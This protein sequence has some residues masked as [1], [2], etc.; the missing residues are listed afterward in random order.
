MKLSHEETI[1]RW[2]LVLG[3]YADKSLGAGADFHGDARLD[4]VDH[5]LDF[6]YGREF[7]SQRGVRQG[8]DGAS[9]LTVPEWI[10]RIRRLFPRGAIEVMERHA[11]DR[12]Q[13]TELLTDPEVL[14]RLEP[15]TELLKSIISMKHLMEGEVVETARRIVRRVVD[16]LKAE[17]EQ[18]VRPAFSG[19]IDRSATGVSGG[20]RS[21]DFRRT[22][23]RNLHTY[24]VRHARLM[25]E[26]VYFHGHVRRFN[27][28]RVII[29]V[30]QS[31]SMLDSVIH[32]A[33]MAGIFAGLSMLDTRLVIFDAEVVDLSDHLDDP[34]ETLMSI[35]L[36]GGTDI[37]GA[38]RYCET[39]MSDP[40]R[41]VLVLVSDLFEGGAYAE[42]YRA[43]QDIITAGAKVVVLTALDRE[44]RP[45]FDRSAAG[46]L[47]SIGANVAAM[48][49][50]KLARWLAQIIS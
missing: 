16:Q 19:R 41:S 20:L 27:P 4:D 5:S 25:V 6:L 28:W 10:A 26:R 23:R 42:M 49:P 9:T 44:A 31:G 8:G 24:D 45:E 21:V 11:I 1:N 33:V 17:L 47:A 48:T 46:E 35:Q 22:I 3:R 39:L 18:H 38:L 13:L 36:G 30:D 14:E 43:V 7:S 50:E 2:R 37:A 32:S 40:R 29:A 15:C 34:V 12:Y